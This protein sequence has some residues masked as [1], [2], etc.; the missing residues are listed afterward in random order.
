LIAFSGDTIYNIKE[1]QMGK[2]EKLFDRWSENIPKEARIP[3]TSEKRGKYEKKS[4]LL[5]ELVV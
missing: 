5:Y 2:A 4:E 1:I 3:M